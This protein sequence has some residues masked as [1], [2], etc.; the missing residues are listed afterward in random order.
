[1]CALLLHLAVFDGALLQAT[2]FAAALHRGGSG[3]SSPTDSGD[4]DEG[5]STTG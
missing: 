2:P 3:R 4:G 5:D 1:M